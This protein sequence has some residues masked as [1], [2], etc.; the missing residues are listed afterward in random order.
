MAPPGCVPLLG[1]DN[2]PGKTAFL[3]TK[4]KL[5]GIAGIAV[6]RYQRQISFS[7]KCP[8]QIDGTGAVRILINGKRG[9]C[10]DIKSCGIIVVS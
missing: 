9:A 3:G 4:H 1:K 7:G 5:G 6:S 2:V 10:S 8:V